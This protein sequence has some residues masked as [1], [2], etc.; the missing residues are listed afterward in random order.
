MGR[1]SQGSPGQ[2]GY[3]LGF[4]LRPGHILQ[5]AAAE[6]LLFGQVQLIQAVALLRTTGTTDVVVY[7][8]HRPTG[9]VWERVPVTPRAP[10]ETPVQPHPD[11]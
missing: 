9:Q 6:S 5:V 7:L 1:R 11:R 2:S 4:E 3:L 10:D 8:I